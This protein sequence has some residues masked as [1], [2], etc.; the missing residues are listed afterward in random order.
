MADA[1][2]LSVDA[3]RSELTDIDKRL[4][5][6][7]GNLPIDRRATVSDGFLA[8]RKA[9]ELADAVEELQKTLQRERVERRKDLEAL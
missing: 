4:T 1:T 9:R 7:M 3:Y 8:L 5:R 6:D 2:T